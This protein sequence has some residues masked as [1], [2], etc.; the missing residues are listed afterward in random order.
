MAENRIQEI[1]QTN[2][3]LLMNAASWLRNRPDTQGIAP[4]THVALTLAVDPGRIGLFARPIERLI[5][6]LVI[7][8]QAEELAESFH[9]SVELL[10]ALNPGSDFRPGSKVLMFGPA[11]GY[12][13]GAAA[14]R[15]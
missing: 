10:K 7:G 13:F 14:L 8:H 12:T 4:H 11:A 2:L 3:D 6:P 5:R 9:M 15:W 1:E